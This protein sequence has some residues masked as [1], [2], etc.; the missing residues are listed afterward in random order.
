MGK[1]SF[2][3]ATGAGC[4]RVRELVPAARKPM[5]ARAFLNGYRL[6]VGERFC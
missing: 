6:S 1:N 3:I 4:L 5:D 2:D